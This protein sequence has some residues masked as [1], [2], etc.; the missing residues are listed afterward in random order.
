MRFGIVLS[1]RGD[2]AKTSPLRNRKRVNLFFGSMVAASPRYG[3]ASARTQV[4]VKASP[5]LGTAFDGR[6]PCGGKT[7]RER[8]SFRCRPSEHD[9]F[10]LT[11]S[12]Q[13]MKSLPGKVPSRSCPPKH[14]DSRD[15]F[16][17]RELGSLRGDEPC[18]AI[19]GD[20]NTLFGGELESASITVI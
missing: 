18:H 5:S 1:S 15:T 10:T 4:T 8:I 9:G 20:F 12:R 6:K 13:V 19:Y 7:N 17:D 11:N 16:T 2:D 14:R 3:V